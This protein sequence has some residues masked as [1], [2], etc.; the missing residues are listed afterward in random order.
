MS[1]VLRDLVSPVGE[2]EPPMDLLARITEREQTLRG[3]RSRLRLPRAAGWAVAAAGVVVVLAGLALAAHSRQESPAGPPSASA[4][5]LAALR[6]TFAGGVSYRRYDTVTEAEKAIG[7][8]LVRPQATLASD[9]SLD[10]IWVSQPNHLATLIWKSGVVEMIQP[11]QCHCTAVEQLTRLGRPFRYLTLNGWPAVTA[12]SNPRA[13]V[14]IRGVVPNSSTERYGTPA[15]VRV[16]QGTI[17]ITLI[18]YGNNVQLGLIGAAHTLRPMSVCRGCLPAHTDAAT[19]IDLAGSIGGVY[20]NESKQ[21]V[22]AMI[23]SGVV[24]VGPGTTQQSMEHPFLRVYYNAADL[25][26]I[27]ALRPGRDPQVFEVITTNS[28]YKTA[29]GLGVGSTLDQARHTPGITCTPGPNGESDCQGGLGY[30][31]PVTSFTVKDGHVVHVFM[32]VVAD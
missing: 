23:G 19:Q 9:Q 8:T 30:Q 11:W 7:F 27:Y 32:A 3:G 21:A 14:L 2:F 16:V 29:T 28:R 1:D 13:S 17:Q 26:V 4:V 22:D 25:T 6:R 10:S 31:K 20:A 18:E 5:N 24:Q 12:P 15:S